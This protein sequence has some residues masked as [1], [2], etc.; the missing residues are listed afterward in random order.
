MP[1]SLQTLVK[2][3]RL[4][5]NKE[6]QNK[7][8]IGGFARFAYHWAREAHGQGQSEAHHTLVDTITDLLRSYENLAEPER[9]ARIAHIIELASSY[10]PDEDAEEPSSDPPHSEFAASKPQQKPA[11]AK[12]RKQK[13]STSEEF[14]SAPLDDWYSGAAQNSD[15]DV[16]ETPRS[17]RERRGYSWQQ[18]QGN[19]ATDLAG[20]EAPVMSLKGVGET[21]REQ[22]QRLGV[23][24]VRDLLFLFPY[25]YD[26]YT[27]MKPISQLA[28]GENVSIIGVIEDVH[29]FSMKNGGKRIES[30]LSDGSLRLQLNWFQQPWIEQQ[31]T[32]GM[33]VVARGRTDQYLGRIV[34]NSPELEELDTDLLHTGRIVP[35][36]P[37]TK[38]LGAKTLR[39]LLHDV[40][41]AWAPLL[42]DYLP[43][44][45]RDSADLMDYGD[46]VAQAHFP[47]TKEDM[48]AAKHRLAFDE[49]FGL[50]VA[51]LQ[52]RRNW[53]SQSGTPFVVDNEWIAS[54]V[55]GL[56]YELTNAQQNAIAEIRHD[57][58]LDIPMN[59]LL[60]GDVGS[61]KTV[62]A[63][64]AIGIAVAH[65]AQAAVMAPTS[66]LAEQHYS[67]LWETFSSSPIGD[68]IQVS[69]LTSN[70]SAGERSAVY[71]DLRSGRI[72]VVVGTQALIQEGVEFANLGL[73]I[74]DEQHR[75]GVAQRGALREKAN[76]NSPHLLVMTA[77]P[78]PRTLALTLHADLDLT[79]IDEMP[80][81]REPV[82][83]RILQPKE[84]ERAYAFIRSQVEQG[85]Q[86]YIVYPLVEES[87]KLDAGSAVA[88]FKRLTKVFPDLELGLLHGRL[89]AGRK[90]S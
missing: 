43:E 56:P 1:S 74:I 70:L 41:D 64:I 65:G 14:E 6:Y 46:A 31:L 9:P 47:D 57:M 51:M 87:D 3:L 19:Q 32:E 52:Q 68:Q 89:P 20:L 38:G 73:A 26:D 86:A 53:Q 90:R 35:V 61:G 78:I 24:T 29:A 36:Y 72:N 84:R 2:I 18:T 55:S 5:Q 16:I 60:Q 76:G 25:R 28:P 37:L 85:H 62:V 71:D 17:V 81:G 58:S 40:V 66:I 75:F 88:G 50:H 27:Q 15:R 82:Q 79:V 4:E 69:L 54:F 63:A 59:R 7:A 13:A 45:I 21:R 8:V 30:F 22:L 23:E 34:M 11:P 33:S 80:P 77:T 48:E 83:T 42:P 12:P 67:N 44:T 10:V 49:L 39:N